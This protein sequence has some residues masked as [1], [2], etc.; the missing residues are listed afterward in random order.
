MTHKKGWRISRL[1][2]LV[3]IT[4][5]GTPSKLKP[6]YFQGSI[7][8]VTPKDMKTWYIKASED[9]ITEEAL[10]A[11]TAKLI[12]PGCILMVIR[13]GVLA[14]TLPIAINK[15]C[16]TINQD[17]KALRCN[18]DVDADYL[19]RALAWQAPALLKRVR[20]T[21]AHNIPT[22]VLRALEVPVPPIAEQ[23]RIAAILDKADGMRRK[24]R[25]MYCHIADL[26]L[27][28]FHQFFGD[29]TRN[30]QGWPVISVA[31]A[32]TV[33]LGRQRAPKYQSG[34]FTRPY[35]RVAN[36]FEDR[37]DL[38]DVLSMDFDASDYARYKLEPDDILLN[39]GQSTELVGRPAMFRGEIADCC[40]QNTLI[41]FRANRAKTEPEYAL[42]V[43]LAYLRSGAFARV[44]SK[45][46]SVA[47]LGA[48]RFAEMPFPL[49]PLQ[50]QQ[51]FAAHRRKIRTLEQE[52]AAAEEQADD[53]FNSLAQQAF[54]GDL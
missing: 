26:Q 8:W 41:R 3:E 24:R 34:N 50:V 35:L 48:A 54:R 22:D 6:E 2:S 30:D 49:P 1:D 17:L 14:H 39:E 16:V 15:V 11:S 37:I 38:S 45:T 31:D 27:S 44:S 43:F 29:I 32:G 10:A 9:H 53:L 40:F 47:H 5:G 13:S 4:G 20:G 25:Q 36:V 33:Q 23:K 12:D 52:N 42:A 51:E 46:S 28:V 21:T 7:P 18:N 19:A